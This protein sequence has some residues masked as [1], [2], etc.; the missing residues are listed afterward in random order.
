MKLKLKRFKTKCLPS[1]WALGSIGLFRLFLGNYAN[2][3]ESRPIIYLIKLYCIFF[4]SSIVGIYFSEV[5]ENDALYIYFV[6]IIEYVLSTII[7]FIYGNKA[8]K[9]YISAIRS[10]DR[11]M[12][13][14]YTSMFTN[15]LHLII[16]F[17][18][19]TRIVYGLI[20]AI[21]KLTTIYG[22]FSI[23]FIVISLDLNSYTII[24]MFSIIQNRINHLRKFLASNSVPINIV[25][26]DDVAHSIRN[27]RKS[28]LYY[29]NLLDAFQ[30]INE[31]LQYL[32]RTFIY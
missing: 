1:D 9:D 30:N 8:Y 2:V 23:F 32:V 5:F 15:Y 3:S 7:F 24:F 22:Y 27:V 29:N 10:H 12:G 4:S 20:H 26:K 18:S 13:F 16:F 6:S 25:G 21:L 31:Q 17:N 28:L 11:I 19:L 14:K